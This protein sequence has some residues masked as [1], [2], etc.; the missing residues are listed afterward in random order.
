MCMLLI[1]L[2]LLTLLS[3]P[4]R[5]QADLYHA[6]ETLGRIRVTIA[7]LAHTWR[8]KLVRTPGGHQ[9]IAADDAG[10]EH[11]LTPESMQGSPAE[12]MLRSLWG[13]GNPRRYLLRHIHLERLDA[14]LRLHS[15]DAALSAL[16]T[17]FIRSLTAFIPHEWRKRTRLR[18][19]PEFVRERSL[20]QA[21]CILHFKLGTIIITAGMLL[22]SIASQHAP[23]AR[24]AA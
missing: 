17:G 8:L 18:V 9:L 15:S 10:S 24:E 4:I 13:S 21:R 3:A 22:A 23:K 14:A 5:V 19:T 11:A 20:L 16:L 7:C 12:R 1:A 2:M 6:D